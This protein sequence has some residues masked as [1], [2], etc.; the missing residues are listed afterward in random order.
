MPTQD[1]WREYKDLHRALER[2]SEA[3]LLHIV[4]PALVHDRA[5]KEGHECGCCGST[6]AKIVKQ[7]PHIEMLLDRWKGTRKFKTVANADSFDKVANGPSVKLIYMPLRC[8]VAQ[9][10]FIKDMRHCLRRGKFRKVLALFGGNRGGKTV[11][12]VEIETDM[13]LVKGGRGKQFWNVAPTG[14]KSLIACR[15]LCEG[16][17]DAVKLP[18]ILHPDLI[19]D[20]PRTEMQIRYK[21]ASLI[22]GSK[23]YFKHAHGEG[24]N[25]KGDPAQGIFVDEGCE[26]RS[27]KNWHIMLNRTMGTKGCLFLSTTPV[28]G[29]WL[30]NEVHTPSA[31]LAE[32]TDS[33]IIVSDSLTCK[34]NPWYSEEQIAETIEALSD[35]R[36]IDREVH[37]LWV[38]MGNVLWEYWNAKAMAR[39]GWR[40]C[41]DLGYI[42][43]TEKLARPYWRKHEGEITSVG[44]LDYNR[45]PMSLI[46]IQI[47]VHEDCE[48]P[49]NPKNWHVFALNEIVENGGTQHLCEIINDGSAAKGLGLHSDHYKKF[50]IAADTTGNQ[51]NPP[52]GHGDATKL[53]SSLASYM[54]SQGLEVIPCNKSRKGRPENPGQ[55]DRLQLLHTIMY[56]GRFHA[57]PATTKALIHSFESQECLPDGRI[58]KAAGDKRDKLSGPTDGLTYGIWR[59][60]AKHEPGFTKKVKWSK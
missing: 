11:T 20:Y 53:A 21:P 56:E 43:I 1:T 27:I 17:H 46:E 37:G 32:A 23:I 14:E 45:F 41:E 60:L 51:A 59:L 36:L 5:R 47:G 49:D 48:D 6:E 39:K 25:L 12:V 8:S 10:A 34:E 16:E 3:R 57:N 42:N 15:K 19:R 18:P 52:S 4:R 26:I 22:D 38:P 2:A 58:D 31:S 44:G 24:G 30:K 54:E 35:P 28:A 40:T 7:V 9:W 29:H 13:I 50:P 55:I 33:D